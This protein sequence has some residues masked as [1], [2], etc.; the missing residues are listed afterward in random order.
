MLQPKE[1]RPAEHYAA[2]EQLRIGLYVHVDMAWFMHPFTLSS[3][4]I[5]SEDQIGELRALRKA[6]FRYDPALSDA[7]VDGAATVPSV[8]TLPPAASIASADASNASADASAATVPAGPSPAAATA[9]GIRELQ[10]RDYRQAV[11]RT[12][13]SFLKA[14]GV[15]RRLN[16]NLLTRPAETM[17]EMADLVGQMVT[18]FLD[19]PEVSLQVMGEHCGGEEAY[20]HSLNVSVLCMMVAKGL[21]LP[22]EQA[23]LLGTAALLH[24]LGMIEIPDH[25]QKKRANEQTRAERELLARHPEYGA[26]LGRK[27]ALSP[28][29]LTVIEQ[30]HELADGSGYPRGLKLEQIDPLARIVSLVNYYDNLCNPLDFGQAMTPHEALSSIF[31]RRRSLFDEQVLQILIRS[32]GVYPPGSVVKLSNESLALVLSVNPVRPMRPW[33]LPYAPGISREDAQMINL[34]TETGLSIGK[35][36][37]PAILPAPVHAWLSPRR[38][39]TYFFDGGLPLEGG[40][41]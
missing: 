34:E 7:P 4:K 25:V 19:R 16:R 9:D 31:A 12:E 15:V 18:A 32:L 38:R 36:L 3:F 26:R 17:A 27:L 35:A 6:R 14:L 2:A 30:H 8:A 13:K 11:A 24:D 39:I 41:P 28:A 23:G 20:Q 33:V 21:E 10:L 22:R 40:R 37:R 29:L 1:A 5:S